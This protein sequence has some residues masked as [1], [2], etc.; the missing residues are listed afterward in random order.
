MKANIISIAKVDIILAGNIAINS[1]DINKMNDVMFEMIYWNR[2]HNDVDVDL[3]I[4]LLELQIENLTDA[5]IDVD[6]LV[7]LDRELEAGR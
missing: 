2:H 4:D 6:F 3:V 5:T 7:K 1:T